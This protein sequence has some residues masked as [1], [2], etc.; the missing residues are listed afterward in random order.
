MTAT[1]KV[2][3]PTDPNL[4]IEEFRLGVWKI[5]IGHVTGSVVQRWEDIKSALP[6]LYRLCFD[7]F[8]IAPY[9]FTFFIF[10]QIWQGVE[11]AILMHFSSTLL[12]QVRRGGLEESTRTFNY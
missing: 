3:A 5:K 11:N 12:R 2:E 7:I 1:E 10:C 9:P 4:T 6:L 8:T